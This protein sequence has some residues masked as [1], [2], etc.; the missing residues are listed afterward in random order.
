MVYLNTKF[1]NVVKKYISFICSLTYHNKAVSEKKKRYSKVIFGIPK[2]Y[3]IRINI[4][5]I[6][7]IKANFLSCNILFTNCYLDAVE[8]MKIVINGYVESKMVRLTFVLNYFN[9]FVHFFAIIYFCRNQYLLFAM[10]E[11]IYI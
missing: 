5:L 3:I 6:I 4:S 11:C 1:I 8:M 10:I 7:P 9:Y 2:H